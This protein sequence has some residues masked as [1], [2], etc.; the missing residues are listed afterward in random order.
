MMIALVFRWIPYRSDSWRVHTTQRNTFPAVPGGCTS[1]VKSYLVP[2]FDVPQVWPVWW[3]DLFLYA[4]PYVTQELVGHISRLGWAH[5]HCPLVR[6]VGLLCHNCCTSLARWVCIP[7][8]HQKVATLPR[9]EVL[10]GQVRSGEVRCGHSQ[11]WH[12]SVLK[13]ILTLQPKLLITIFW[14]TWKNTIISLYV[15]VTFNLLVSLKLL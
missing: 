12:S 6:E 4:L 2:V 8:C 5:R 7:V 1:E 13:S 3:E 14:I 10:W 15:T 11:V 9:R